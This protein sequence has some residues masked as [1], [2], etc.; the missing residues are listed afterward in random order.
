MSLATWIILGGIAGWIVSLLSGRDLKGGCLG[1]VL[2]GMIGAV[3]GGSLFRFFGGSGV[4]GLNLYSVVVAVIG[5]LV[6]LWVVRLATG[7]RRH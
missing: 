1:L 6:L 4:T 5:A 3:V 7:G 2:V